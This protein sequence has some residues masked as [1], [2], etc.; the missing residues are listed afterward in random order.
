MFIEG[1]YYKNKLFLGVTDG[2]L[3]NI[4]AIHPDVRHERFSIL[5]TEQFS[6]PTSLSNNVK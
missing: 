4:D 1:V 5:A 6:P 2:T 3:Y